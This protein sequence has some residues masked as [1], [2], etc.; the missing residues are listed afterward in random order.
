MILVPQRASRGQNARVQALILRF[1]LWLLL[2]AAAPCRRVDREV[3]TSAV[4]ARP[5]RG[6]SQLEN[7]GRSPPDAN[8]SEEETAGRRRH[9]RKAAEAGRK[10]R[11]EVDESDADDAEEEEEEEEETRDEEEEEEEEDGAENDDDDGSTAERAAAISTARAAQSRR[12]VSVDLSRGRLRGPV[13]EGDREAAKRDPY[14][15]PASTGAR[16]DAR[17]GRE[18]VRVA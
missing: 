11:R 17:A 3:L 14:R 2:E 4:P 13:P 8:G 15:P 16:R 18:R 10:R 5:Q 1:T 12:G 7:L 9:S 6:T